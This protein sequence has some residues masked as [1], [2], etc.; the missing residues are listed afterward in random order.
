MQVA[1]REDGLDDLVAVHGERGRVGRPAQVPR[2]LLK[3]KPEPAT[4]VTVTTCPHNKAAVA[5]FRVIDR[6][7]AGETAVVS[8]YCALASKFAETV[9]FPSMTI[10]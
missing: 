9:L 4:A 10:V 1:Q 6:R 8:V 5:G 2:Q 3:A 7:A